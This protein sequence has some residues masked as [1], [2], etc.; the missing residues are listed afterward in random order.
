MLACPLFLTQT[1]VQTVHG[2][3]KAD[4]CRYLFVKYRN[5]YIDHWG[6]RALGCQR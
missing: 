3:T 5:L 2:L 6:D 1:H 4:G